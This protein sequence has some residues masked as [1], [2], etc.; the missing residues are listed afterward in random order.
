MAADFFTTEVWTLRGLVTYC[1]VFVIE[2]QS[3]RVSIVG[4]TPYP[5]DAF[6]L[7]IVRQLIEATEGALNG[8]RFFVCHRDQKWSTG[9]RE[10]LEASGM[11][12]VRPPFRHRTAMRMRSGVCARS[13][14]SAWIV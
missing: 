2:L 4:S 12:V 13:R 10:L 8:R 11:R 14:K 7:Q 3:R 5:D 6:M 9:V 1:T